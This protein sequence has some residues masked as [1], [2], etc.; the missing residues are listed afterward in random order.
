MAAGAGA[1]NPGAPRAGTSLPTLGLR[2]VVALPVE[3]RDAIL[4]HAR[5]QAPIEAC[6]LVAGTAPAASGGIPTTWHP[7]ANGFAS[8]LRFE[9]PPEEVRRLLISFDERG[10]VVWAIVHSHV[11]S[12][13]VPSAT[14]IASAE[15]WP[16]ALHV[17]VSLDPASA[18]P[19]TGDPAV[20]AWHIA[21]GAATEVVLAIA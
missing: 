3:L 8:P 1:A 19:V 10:D 13:A 15:W 2:D 18:D 14:D 6:G 17:L 21:D 5:S 11:R 9:I 12:P 7:T 20:R 16:G 4:A